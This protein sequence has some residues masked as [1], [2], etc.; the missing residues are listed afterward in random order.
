MNIRPNDFVLEIGSGHNPKTRSDVLCDKFIDDDEQRGGNLVVDRP[1]VEAD[2]QY[3]P[4]AEK[5]FD[6]VICSHV[7]E[8]VEDPKLL[9]SEL[10]RVAHR[11]Y[12]E[13]PSEIGERIYG[14]QYHNWIVN[15]I[16]GR[17]VLKKNDKRAEFGLL[18][19]TLAETNTHWRRFHILHHNL[20]LVQY[21]WDGKIEYQIVDE[22]KSPL[23]GTYI[24]LNCTET[25]VELLTSKNAKQNRNRLLLTLKSIIPRSVVSYTKSFIAKKRKPHI[26]S[27]DA[28]S[29]YELLVCPK[30]KGEVTFNEQNIHCIAC[31]QRYPIVDG[32]PRFT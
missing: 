11:G 30:C 16:D 18:F 12:I 2:G 9:I 4:F 7:L 32:I 13:T 14:W 28:K 6:Y 31:K 3:L 10:M 1:I 27:L 26:K 21:E 5:A 17:L 15:L 23:P 19:H 29:F 22:D 20:F 25:I 8:H 24:D